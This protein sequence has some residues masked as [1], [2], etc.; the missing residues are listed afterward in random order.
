MRQYYLV[1]W[2]IYK[3]DSVQ[4]DS[5]LKSSQWGNEKCKV[6][7][8]YLQLHEKD[9]DDWCRGEVIDDFL[10]AQIAWALGWDKFPSE[11]SCQKKSNLKGKDEECK[12]GE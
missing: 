6:R 3:E 9:Q 4:I 10:L 5:I 7:A 2:S 1:P 11:A 8:Q 12:N